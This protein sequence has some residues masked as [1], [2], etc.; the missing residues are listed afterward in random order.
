ME[1]ID[2]INHLF[3]DNLKETLAPGSKLKIAA[4]CF[5]IYAYEALKNELEQIESL[6]FIF[7]SP[8]SVKNQVADTL[9]K[10]QRE[11]HIPKHKRENNLYGTEFELRLK[12]ELTQKA[13]AKECAEWIRSKA[14]FRSNT[15]TAPMQQFVC[16][17][18]G[19]QHTTYQPLHGFTAVDLGYQKGDAVSNFI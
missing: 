11:F 12:N 2:N 3:G 16:V 6:Q 9:R 13:I 7:T 18:N 15:S 4:S 8:T 10:E 19:N 5:S 14:S 1:L 17:E